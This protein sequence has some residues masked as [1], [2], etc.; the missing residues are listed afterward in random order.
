MLLT[1]GLARSNNLH[2]MSTRKL[3]EPNLDKVPQPRTGH[4]TASVIARLNEQ[5]SQM[6]SSLMVESD[7]D[8]N[9]EAPPGA[10][11]PAI[12]PDPRPA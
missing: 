11:T 7:E 5:L 8:A 9:R 2:A 3:S 1:D 12:D 4:G 6:E 10:T